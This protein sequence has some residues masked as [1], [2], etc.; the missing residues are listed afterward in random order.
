MF[1]KKD[2][3]KHIESLELDVQR[4]QEEQSNQTLKQELADLSGGALS[5]MASWNLDKIVPRDDYHYLSSDGESALDKE[6]VIG[7]LGGRKVII[8]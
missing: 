6:Q 3:I 5:H 2:L 7:Y 1:W 4:L 8:K